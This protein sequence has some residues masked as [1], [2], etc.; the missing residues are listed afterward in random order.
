MSVLF[1]HI[2]LARPI[3][4]GKEH[5]MIIYMFSHIDFIKYISCG[6]RRMSTPGIKREPSFWNKSLKPASLDPPP[7]TQVPS[8]SKEVCATPK[9]NPTTLSVGSSTL[10]MPYLL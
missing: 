6:R 4:Y 9:T 8:E 10:K 1:E 3:A 7:C 5:D 2:R